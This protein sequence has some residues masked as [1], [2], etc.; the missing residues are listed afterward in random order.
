MFLIEVCGASVAGVW[1]SSC[2]P[3]GVAFR[4]SE[5]EREFDEEMWRSEGTASAPSDQ[6]ALMLSDFGAEA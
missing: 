3:V 5:R 2:T 4:E 1:Q 6:E